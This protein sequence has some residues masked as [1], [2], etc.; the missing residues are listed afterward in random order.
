MT[1][2]VLSLTNAGLAAVQA[3]SGTD[4][5]VIAQLGLTATPF[6]A[7]PT[8][9]ALP[10]EFKRI[11]AVAG[12]AA[13]PNLTHMTAYDTSAEVWTATGLG[14]WLADGTLFAVYSAATT[15]INKAGAAFAMIGFDIAFSADLA[16]SISFGTPVFTNPPATTEM[17]GL[18]ELAT[19]AEALAGSDVLRAL[20]PQAARAA[21]LAWLLTADGSGSGLDAD[22]LDGQDGSWYAN[23]V[24]RL[25]Y[26]P[27]DQLAYTAASVL[28]RLITVDGS[29]SGLDADMLDGRD[30]T[31]FQSAITVTTTADGTCIAVPIGA[32]K[33]KIQMGQVRAPLASGSSVTVTFPQTLTAAPLVVMH[34]VYDPSNSYN[35]AHIARA[36]ADTTGATFRAVTDDSGSNSV[37]GFDWLAIGFGT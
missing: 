11:G 5:V 35:Q 29:G 7:A 33:L 13:A 26:T 28:A 2:I 31:A 34:A 16:A 19:V 27:L 3:A 6:E 30:S 23:I 14:L 18:V 20:T 4:P 12:T 25:G 22:L 24:A 1:A 15:I 8:L 36:G 21:V 37:P 17:R 10:G 32:S 9:T